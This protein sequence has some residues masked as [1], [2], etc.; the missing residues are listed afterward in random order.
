MRYDAAARQRRG[1][2]AR[3][4]PG[5]PSRAAREAVLERDGWCCQR[6]GRALAGAAYSLQHRLPRGRAGGNAPA[7][8]VLV[9]GSATTPGGCHNWIEH[10]DRRAAT[11]EGWLVPSGIAPEDWPVR[12]HDDW[13]LPGETRWAPCLPH[14][15]QVDPESRWAA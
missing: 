8:L 2:P 6:C 11:R 9:C 12:R 15:L 13:A 4:R 1:L 14:P 7:N 5:S 10:Q 3:P